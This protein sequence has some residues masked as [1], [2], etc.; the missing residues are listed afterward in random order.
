MM[1]PKRTKKDSNHA[2][3]RDNLRRVGC[4]VVDVADLPGDDLHNP[5]DLFILSPCEYAWLQAEVKPAQDSKFTDSEQNYLES[6]GLWP[7]NLTETPVVVIY[8]HLWP[9]AWF[10]DKCGCDKCVAA[11]LAADREESEREE[12]S[13]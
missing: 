10:V 5:L 3:V 2:D 4:R 13:G 8:D 7:F 11:F 6:L 12:K 9:L 1:R